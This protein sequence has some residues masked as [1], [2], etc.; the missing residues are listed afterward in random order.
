MGSKEFELEEGTCDFCGKTTA[1]YDLYGDF[2]CPSC[3]VDRS[4]TEDDCSEDV[5]DGLVE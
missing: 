4:S 5:Y 2:I 1:V 3:S